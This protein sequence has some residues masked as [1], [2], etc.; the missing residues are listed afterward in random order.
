MG[1]SSIHGL[2]WAKF[3]EKA[4]S[5]R[6]VLAKGHSTQIPSGDES[7]PEM[8]L[9]ANRMGCSMCHYGLNAFSSSTG[10]LGI[11]PRSRSRLPL[12]RRRHSRS[13]PCPPLVVSRLCS[14]S[15][16]R[17]GSR[18]P[19]TSGSS[20]CESPS[21]NALWWNKRY[22]WNPMFEWVGLSNLPWLRCPCFLLVQ[23]AWYC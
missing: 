7:T 21:L 17:R 2:H 16:S 20:K 13:G 9:A 8:G 3:K 5:N 11:S 15:Q 22:L 6:E 10:S 4:S 12:V 18:R 1:M 14:H 19:S 23:H